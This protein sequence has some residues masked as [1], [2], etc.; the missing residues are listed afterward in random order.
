MP[1]E[2]AGVLRLILPRHIF[3]YAPLEDSNF[4]PG[5]VVDAV[6]NSGGSKHI[7]LRQPHGVH[8][9]PGEARREA[10]L[11]LERWLRN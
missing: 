1:F 7:V 4:D 11:F 2:F 6:R 3:V 5:G 9:F 8:D 10:Y